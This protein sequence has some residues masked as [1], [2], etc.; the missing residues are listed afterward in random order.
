MTLSFIG[1]GMRQVY[2]K[3]LS[4]KYLPG[5]EGAAINNTNKSFFSHALTFCREAVEKS[6]SL[7]TVSDQ[8]N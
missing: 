7:F 3:R 5:A 8:E 4:A 1:L 2:I 6:K